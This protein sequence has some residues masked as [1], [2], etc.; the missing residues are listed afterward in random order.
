[1]TW[2]EGDSAQTEDN[3]DSQAVFQA[4][5]TVRLSDE[6]TV[7]LV[8]QFYLLDT[9]RYHVA[10]DDICGISLELS[11]HEL[12]EILQWSQIASSVARFQHDKA[13]LSKKRSNATLDAQ[14]GMNV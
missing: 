3:P 12:G 6:L 11:L 8:S 10:N 7:D 1:M 5:V 2:T 13:N 14:K 4:G 9:L